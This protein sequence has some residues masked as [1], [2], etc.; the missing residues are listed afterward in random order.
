M[1]IIDRVRSIFGSPVEPGERRAR[2]VDR[3][4]QLEGEIRQLQRQ[5]RSR[6]GRGEDVSD[7]ESRITSL[8]AQHYQ[9][10]LKID[11]TR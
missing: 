10:R 7:L 8:Q 5:S 9:L 2:L 1:S 11:R 3:K 4:H 6:A